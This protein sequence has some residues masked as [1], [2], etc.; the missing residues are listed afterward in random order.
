M[1]S[2]VKHTSLLQ[3]HKLMFTENIYNTE[4]ETQM[5]STKKSNDPEKDIFRFLGKSVFNVAKPFSLSPTKRQK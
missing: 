1:S 4:H 2:Y 3:Q 5:S